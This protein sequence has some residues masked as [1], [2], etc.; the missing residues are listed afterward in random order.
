MVAESELSREPLTATDSNGIPAMR[1]TTSD[2]IAIPREMFETMY[3]NP[4]TRV[5]GQL[6][7]ILAN[8]TPL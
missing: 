4:E 5:K 1:Q 2:T 8:P 3:L 6:R 7:R